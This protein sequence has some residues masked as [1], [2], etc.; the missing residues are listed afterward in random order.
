[1]SVFSGALGTLP[2]TSHQCRYCKEWSAPLT[3]TPYLHWR[4]LFGPDRPHQTHYPVIAT[5]RRRATVMLW[6]LRGGL[7]FTLTAFTLWPGVIQCVG[8][9]MGTL[10][11][12]TLLLAARWEHRALIDAEWARV[13][14][15]SSTTEVL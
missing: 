6:V 7:G 4:A 14:S 15:D 8:G 3:D 2:T 12:F 13:C 1:V 10:V 11:A 5:A 9:I